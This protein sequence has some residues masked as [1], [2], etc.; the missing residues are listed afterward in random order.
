VQSCSAACASDATAQAPPLLLL[1]VVLL[2][3]LLVI[4]PV[5]LSLQEQQLQPQVEASCSRDSALL[6]CILAASSCCIATG[7]HLSASAAAQA[8]TA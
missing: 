7:N 4:V 5:V 6:E 3:L 8:S 2:L 1:L